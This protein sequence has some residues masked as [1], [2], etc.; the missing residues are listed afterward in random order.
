MP[1]WSQ[2][3]NASLLLAT[4]RAESRTWQSSA[5]FRAERFNMCRL[6]LA[7]FFRGRR[8]NCL[9][10]LDRCWCWTGVPCATTGLGCC[11]T[12]GC[13]TTTAWTV[14]LRRKQQHLQQYAQEVILAAKNKTNPMTNPA[15]APPFVSQQPVSL[16]AQHVGLPHISHQRSDL[17]WKAPQSP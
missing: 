1:G 11:K 10:H 17:I 9:T 16:D 13:W 6:W 3:R 8:R 12:V 4:W 5:A 15:T 14:G 7:R 2:T